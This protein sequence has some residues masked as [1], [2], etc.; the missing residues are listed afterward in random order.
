MVVR[1]ENMDMLYRAARLT[2]GVLAKH[3]TP[4][5]PHS[6]HDSRVGQSAEKY[7]AHPGFPRHPVTRWHRGMK[8]RAEAPYRPREG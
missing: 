7:H 5:S 4:N 1:G 8:R 2:K 3:D 6:E